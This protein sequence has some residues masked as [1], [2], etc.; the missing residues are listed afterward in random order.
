MP[1]SAPHPSPAS[2]GNNQ[3]RDSNPDWQKLFQASVEE[4]DPIWKDYIAAATAFDNRM[5]DEW[6]KVIDGVLVYVSF[7]LF[8]DGIC[9]L[10]LFFIT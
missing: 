1:T 9:N 2:L 3:P 4:D 5:I 8:I 6:N 10:P 7:G